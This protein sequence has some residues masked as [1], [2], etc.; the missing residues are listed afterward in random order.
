MDDLARHILSFHGWQP[1]PSARAMQKYWLLFPWVREMAD[2][3]QSRHKV[4]TY[5]HAPWLGLR[6]CNKCDR[7]IR[8][9]W[10]KVR[11]KFDALDSDEESLND[12]A[13]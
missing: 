12:L 2:L 13:L 9:E 6:D 8:H 5:T 1:T 4:K 11:R 7:C 10:W 3:F